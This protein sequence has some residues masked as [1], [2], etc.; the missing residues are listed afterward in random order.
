[1][2]AKK[3]QRVGDCD[4]AGEWHNQHHERRLPSR[5]IGC[6]SERGGQFAATGQNEVAM[7]ANTKPSSDSPSSG[8][9]EKM[10]PRIG[11]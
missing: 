1:M 11:E 5:G 10:I 7:A 6:A 9:L 8:P 4:E 3:R 2:I